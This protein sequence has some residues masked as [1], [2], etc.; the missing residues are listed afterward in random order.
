VDTD[1]TGE[2]EQKWIKRIGDEMAQN[3]LEESQWVG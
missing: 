3:K 2:E 1:R